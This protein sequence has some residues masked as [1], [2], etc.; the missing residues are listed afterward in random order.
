MQTTDGYGSNKNCQR[1][2]G[3]EDRD[4][5]RNFGNLNDGVYLSKGTYAEV[6][7]H[8]TENTE[9][10]SQRFI[11]LAKAVLNVIHRTAGDIAVSIDSTIFYSQQAFRIFGC[12]TEEGSQPHPE[13]C[14]GATGLNCGSNTDNV[15]GTNSCSKS[16]TQCFKAVYVTMTIILGTEDKL[17]G[18]RQLQYLQQ[19]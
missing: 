12:H 8:D 15:T 14:T 6:C 1:N 11:L 5:C 9:H 18:L 16:G 10:H 2:A 3:I 7:A 17:Q 19:A 4:A 13:Q